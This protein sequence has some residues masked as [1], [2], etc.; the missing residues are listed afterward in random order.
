MFRLKYGLFGVHEQR[1]AK[2][3]ELATAMTCTTREI[4]EDYMGR[5]CGRCGV[6]EKFAH[7]FGGKA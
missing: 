7:D 1:S 4:K 3:R 2:T 6:D 5:K